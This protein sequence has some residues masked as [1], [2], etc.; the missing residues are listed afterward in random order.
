MRQAAAAQR[1]QHLL[2]RHETKQAERDSAFAMMGAGRGGGGGGPTGLRFQPKFAATNRLTKRQRGEGLITEKEWDEMFESHEDTGKIFRYVFF[3]AIV[4]LVAILSYS[5]WDTEMNLEIPQ[6]ESGAGFVGAVREGDVDAAETDGGSPSST[7]K[8]TAGVREAT[9][10]EIEE[11]Y[12]L[13]GVKPPKRVQEKSTSTPSTPKESAKAAAA[14]AKERRRENYRTKQA[15]KKSVRGPRQFN[16]SVGV[17]WEELRCQAQAGRGSVQR[18]VIAG[19]PRPL[20]CAA[21]TR[22]WRRPRKRQKS[23]TGIIPEPIGGGV[24]EEACGDRSRRGGERRGHVDGAG[25]AEGR[26]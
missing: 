22:R 21:P 16:V 8:T 10:Q 26:V 24:R 20:Q 13:L 17:L 19:G 2:D 18:V 1:Q 23:A 15:L 3:I 14:A 7:S 4:V 11:Y 12:K 5:K 6:I 9:K 25:G